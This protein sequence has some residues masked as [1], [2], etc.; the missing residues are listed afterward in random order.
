M[1]NWQLIRFSAGNLGQTAGS[2][3][4]PFPLKPSALM[5]LHSRTASTWLVRCE[6]EV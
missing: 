2:C 3:G 4:R 5:L 6:D 1:E